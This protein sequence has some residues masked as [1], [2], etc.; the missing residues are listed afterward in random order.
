MELENK[1]QK[2]S[3]TFFFECSTELENLL[4]NPICGKENVLLVQEKVN[5][6]KV[7]PRF[8]ISFCSITTLLIAIITFFRQPQI[9]LFVIIIRNQ[10]DYIL[11]NHRYRNE[12]A[13][14]LPGGNIQSHHNPVIGIIEQ[15]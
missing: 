11:V 12:S 3:S 15:S 5:I 6:L 14:I 4:N 10:I 1:K 2:N 7:M 8:F 9:C 13:K